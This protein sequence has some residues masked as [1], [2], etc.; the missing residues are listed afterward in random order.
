[1]KVAMS[2]VRVGDVSVDD[3]MNTEHEVMCI[4]CQTAK[5]LGIHV[6]GQFICI[7]CERAIV[8]TDVTDERYFHYIACMKQIWL[9][10]TS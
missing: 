3:A 9:A 5:A 10:A 6:C 7:D 2:N 4:V 1:M 8:S